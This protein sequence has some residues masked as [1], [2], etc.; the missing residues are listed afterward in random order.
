MKNLQAKWAL[1]SRG[2]RKEAREG[3]KLGHS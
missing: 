3:E 1:E 2:W